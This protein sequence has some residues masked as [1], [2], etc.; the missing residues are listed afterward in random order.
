VTR[1]RLAHR[2]QSNVRRDPNP[3]SAGRRA[4]P[5]RP[6]SN[7]TI[8]QHRK[9]NMHSGPP[10][11]WYDS[12]PRWA[13]LLRHLNKWSRSRYSSGRS[14]RKRWPLLR[15]TVMRSRTRTRIPPWSSR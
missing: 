1:G 13:T 7:S 10:S 5:P 11:S 14:L 6:G 12:S 8:S 9:I 15:N 3:S 2:V 4:T